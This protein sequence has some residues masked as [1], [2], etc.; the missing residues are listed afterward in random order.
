MPSNGNAAGDAAE[1]R[2]PAADG[3]N[4]PSS[5]SRLPAFTGLGPQGPK[6]PQAPQFPIGSQNVHGSDGPS[7]A[8]AASVTN[9][10]AGPGQGIQ[11][12]AADGQVTVPPAGQELRLPIFDSL[13]S[14]WFRRS[15]KSLATQRPQGAQSAPSAQR[16]RAGHLDIARRRG[17]ACGR[18]GGGTRGRRNYSGRACQ[19]GFRGLISCQALSAAAAAAVRE[20]QGVRE[21]RKQKPK[22][23]SGRRMRPVPAWPASSE[24]YARVAPPHPRSRSRRTR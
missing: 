23:P 16:G 3:P 11:G 4:G 12:D 21:V 18:G 20:A 2:T 14:D 9:G 5:P 8:D 10:A 24:A 22:R 15:G 7:V 17:L 6:A 13:E 19:G 1:P